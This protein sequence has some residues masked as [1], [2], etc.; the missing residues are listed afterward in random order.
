VAPKRSLLRFVVDDTTVVAD[1][2]ARRP[3]RG[4]YTCR[5]EACFG[6][7]RARGGFNRAFRRSVRAPLPQETVLEARPTA[8]DERQRPAPPA[9][10][11][12]HLRQK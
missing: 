10:E 7:A 11:N 5:T 9:H 4:A 3:G 1:Q 6:Q 2:E 12:V 8:A